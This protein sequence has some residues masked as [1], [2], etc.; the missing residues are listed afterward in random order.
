MSPFTID[1]NSQLAIRAIARLPVTK[2]A[3][4]RR[5]SVLRVIN[6]TARGFGAAAG[7]PNPPADW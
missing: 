7:K 4:P 1:G 2:L 5:T 6:D 3:L